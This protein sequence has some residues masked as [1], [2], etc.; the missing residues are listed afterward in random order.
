L[1]SPFSIF[2]ESLV[3]ARPAAALAK[4]RCL[5]LS[6]LRGLFSSTVFHISSSAQR[7]SPNFALLIWHFSPR[8]R[9][10]RLILGRRLLVITRFFPPPFGVFSPPELLPPAPLPQPRPWLLAKPFRFSGSPAGESS[11]PSSDSPPLRIET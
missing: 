11:F 8:R 9:F 7:S 4:A 6:L 3:F 10:L 5:P 2:I 1:F